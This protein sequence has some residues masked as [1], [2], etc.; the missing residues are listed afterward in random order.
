VARRQLLVEGGNDGS[1]TTARGQLRVREHAAQSLGRCLQLTL[2]AIFL[3]RVNAATPHALSVIGPWCGCSAKIHT[4]PQLHQRTHL[5]EREQLQVL[6]LAEEQALCGQAVA[7][8]ATHLLRV[9]LEAL[10]HS[11][12]T[13]QKQSRLARATWPRTRTRAAHTHA[14]MHTHTQSARQRRAPRA[15]RS[16]R[17]G[18][19]R[20][21]RCPCR[22][23]RLR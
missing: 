9:R 14:H 4:N 5:E 13:G 23:R 16:A 20:A 6:R 18:G 7:T 15:C 19:C 8:S 11:T 17:R 21:C 1:A 22:R 12:T 3:T 2:V 10:S